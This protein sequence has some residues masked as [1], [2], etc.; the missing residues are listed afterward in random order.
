VYELH[1][2]VAENVMRRVLA[3]QN[4]GGASDRRIADAARVIEDA[5]SA[6]EFALAS[7]QKRESLWKMRGTGTIALE[8]ALNETVERRLLDLEVRALEFL[9][10]KEEELARIIDDE[11]TPRRLLEAHLRRLPVRLRPRPASKLL[12]DIEAAGQGA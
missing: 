3:Y 6:G 12:A 4:I 11:L 5:G 10:K 9:W 7:T 8:I 1:G 2:D